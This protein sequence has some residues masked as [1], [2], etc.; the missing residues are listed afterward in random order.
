MTPAP[1]RRKV[2]PEWCC[3]WLAEPDKVHFLKPA[4]AAQ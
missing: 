4:I 1:Q 3:I 2:D